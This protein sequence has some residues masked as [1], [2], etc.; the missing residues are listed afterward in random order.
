MVTTIGTSSDMAKMVENFILLEHDAIAAY[1]TTI[2]RLESPAHKAKVEEF[3]QDHLRHLSD[4]TALAGRVGANVPREG[5]MKE[6]LTTGKIKL[7]DMVGGDG[8]ILKAMATNEIDTISAYQHAVDN[9]AV[10][11]TDKE[12]FRRGLADER[13]HKDWMD[14]AAKAA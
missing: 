6:L 12:L 11:A 3:R 7:A 4:L 5:D 9:E 1:G 13:K 8:A 10:P 14:Q 2:E